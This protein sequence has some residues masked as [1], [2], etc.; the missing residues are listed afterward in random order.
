MPIRSRSLPRGWYPDEPESLRRLV[1]S[2]AG[3]ESFEPFRG[4]AR[5]A[6]AP[7]AGWT[8]SGRL[9]ALS[10]CSLAAAKAA[11]PT[12]A[13]FGGHLPPGARPLAAPE[14]GFETPLGVLPADLELLS[15]L[16]S[17]I[18]SRNGL[19]SRAG[20]AKDDSPDNTVEVL[21]PLV[22]ALL[23][24]ARVLWLRVP[25][26]PTALEIGQALHAAAISI[27]RELFCLGST[28]LTH[29]GPNYGFSPKGRGAAAEYWVRSTNDR[30]F[31]DA[32]LGL[33]GLEAIRL[34]EEERSACS[35]GAAAAALAFAQASG[36]S[37]AELFGY[38]TSL[39]VRRDESFVGYASIGFF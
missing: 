31:I 22:A 39:D 17:H 19:D 3:A 30:R 16:G 9:A 33:D 29:Y 38:A 21:L 34:G 24:G 13:V 20:L 28:D 27:G 12:V 36:S 6:V 14:S 4:Q 15:A 5:A 26:D 35:S 8:F 11:S 10:V 18:A 25:N 23:P 1:S 32:L 37:R 7:H 2:W